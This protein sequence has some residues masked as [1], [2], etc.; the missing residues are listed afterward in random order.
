LAVGKALRDLYLERLRFLEC[1]SLI[2]DEIWTREEKRR[3]K[4]GMINVSG[5]DNDAYQQR[6]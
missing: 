5:N 3:R 6:Q 4:E 1:K 2:T